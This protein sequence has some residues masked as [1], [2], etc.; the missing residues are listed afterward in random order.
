M[1][2]KLR[3]RLQEHK[4]EAARLRDEIGDVSEALSSLAREMFE[5]EAVAPSVQKNG[6]YVEDDDELSGW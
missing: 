3:Q 6:R 4:V 1:S 2:P 5:P